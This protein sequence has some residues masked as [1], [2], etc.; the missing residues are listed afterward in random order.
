MNIHEY[1]AKQILKSYGVAI[2]EGIVAETPAAAVQAA[3]EQKAA[4]Q[5]AAE[6]AAPGM[7]SNFATS[8]HS[9]LQVLN[10]TLK[11]N[12]RSSFYDGLR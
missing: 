12:D 11:Q 9:I 4:E 3:A 6:K 10:K 8:A 1:Q 2:Q 5:A 7:G